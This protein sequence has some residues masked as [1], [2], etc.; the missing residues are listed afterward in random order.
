MGDRV[1]DGG[2]GMGWDGMKGDGVC[3][4]GCNDAV[5]D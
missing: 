5:Y 3:R 1:R 4:L 2:Y